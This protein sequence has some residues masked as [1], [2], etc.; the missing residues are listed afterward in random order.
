MNDDAS[1]MMI[2]SALIIAAWAAAMGAVMVTLYCD[3][4][5]W[6][7]YRKEN[8]HCKDGDA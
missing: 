5:D 8:K 6:L 3:T 1:F 7:R 4:R 2:A